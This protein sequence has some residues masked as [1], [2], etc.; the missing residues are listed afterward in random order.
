MMYHGFPY[1]SAKALKNDIRIDLYSQV[2]NPTLEKETSHS[3]HNLEGKIKK[4]LS[5]G[6]NYHYRA[7]FFLTI[8]KL[9]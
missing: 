7:E 5:L 1:H 9:N 6:A 4:A 8:T 2:S 3:N